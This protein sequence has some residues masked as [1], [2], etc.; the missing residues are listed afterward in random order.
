MTESVTGPRNAAMV[1]CEILQVIPE[2]QTI[3]REDLTRF[4]YDKL[5]YKAPELLMHS[6]IW[7]EFESIMKK[8]IVGNETE[9]W[10]KK[11]VLIYVGNI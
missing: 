10:K 9:E 11:C 3:F 1:V 7:N 2:E 4:L 6:S 8:H 5:A